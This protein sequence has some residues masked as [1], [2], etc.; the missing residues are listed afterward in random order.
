M[1]SIDNYLLSRLVH[2][3]NSRCRS[4]SNIFSFICVNSI[5]V[6]YLC[7][8]RQIPRR[9]ANFWH[10]QRKIT[11]NI[12]N[13]IISNCSL[14]KRCD[15]WCKFTHVILDPNILLHKLKC[16]QIQWQLHIEGYTPESCLKMSSIL[17]ISRNIPQSLCFFSHELLCLG[18]IEWL[19]FNFMLFL[20]LQLK[21]QRAAKF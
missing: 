4:I 20:S 19:C 5:N 9:K 3:N 12:D 18:W 6:Q 16:F 15:K 7:P 2:E 13:C 8:Q 14:Y 10:S 17:N 21:C 11:F 1:L